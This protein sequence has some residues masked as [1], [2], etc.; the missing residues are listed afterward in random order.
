MP[1]IAAVKAVCYH[2]PEWRPWANLMSS[3]DI[4][5]GGSALDA[6]SS[7]DGAT[8]VVRQELEEPVASRD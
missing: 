4:N 2:V 5:E 3:H 8:E 1:L 6:E 7:V